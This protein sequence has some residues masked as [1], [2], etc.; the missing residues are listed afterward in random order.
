MHKP[1]DVTSELKALAER[2][3]ALRARH[4]QQWGDL[5][6]ALKAD[7]LGPEVV[8]GM[9]LELRPIPAQTEAAWRRAGAAWLQERQSRRSRARPKAQSAPPE[10][11]ARA[12]AQG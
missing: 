2:S 7:E 10:E 12:Q 5:L 8:A 11:A 4:A 9:L 3:R 6:L 1:S